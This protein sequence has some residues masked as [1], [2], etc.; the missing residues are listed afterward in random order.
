MAFSV[1]NKRGDTFYLHS[2][3]VELANNRERTIYF[4]SKEQKAGV[5]NSLPSGWE[6][7]ETQNGLPV[8]RR[9]DKDRSKDESPSKAKSNR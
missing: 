5:M 1:K 9:T 3:D 7:Y 2:K 6:V 8:L 4:F